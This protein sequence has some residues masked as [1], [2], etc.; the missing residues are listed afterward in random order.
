[1]HGDEFRSLLFPK[2]CGSW[3]QSC[4]LFLQS[5][6][7]GTD[8]CVVQRQEMTTALLGTFCLLEERGLV[9]L[10]AQDPLEV[11]KVGTYGEAV[12]TVGSKG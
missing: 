3:D 8:H 9:G 6:T 12:S 2:V 5:G 1:M 11:G 4:S 7:A 10:N